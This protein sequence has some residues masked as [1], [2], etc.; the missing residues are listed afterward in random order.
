MKIDKLDYLDIALRIAGFPFEKKHV[1][2]IIHLQELIEN[3]K[4]K[5]S[6]NDVIDIQYE[7]EKKWEMIEL[8][9]STK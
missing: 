4:G 7:I 9:K 8:E 6:M 2:L 3:R 1:D 5:A